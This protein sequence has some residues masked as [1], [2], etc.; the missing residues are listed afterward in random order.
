MSTQAT[1]SQKVSVLNTLKT[2]T[3]RRKALKI[4]G[5]SFHV[6]DGN[7]NVVAFSKQK[8]FK[9]REDI[10]VYTDE[11]LK[12]ELLLIRAQKIVD[13]SSAYGV[14]DPQ[15]SKPV[16]LARRKG[17]SSILR[18]SW[19]VLDQNGQLIGKLTEDNL[20]LALARR[21]V[22]D[23]IP[24]KFSL[25]TPDGRAQAAFRVHFNPLIYK[26]SVNVD[27]RC[28]IDPRLV[29]ASAVLIAAI[30]GRQRG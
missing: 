15:E 28:V 24:Q 23:L 3:I 25:K 29:F 11:T 14:I 21:F 1:V 5:A 22:C 12:T 13:F 16:G 10:R 4:F 30:E 2:Y 7:G 26:L 27:P 17:W 6:L 8:A 20:T 19:E 9:L 18:D